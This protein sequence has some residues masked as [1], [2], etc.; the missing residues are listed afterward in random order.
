V[1]G[2]IR[3]A[4]VLLVLAADAATVPAAPGRPLSYRPPVEPLQVVRPFDAPATPYG[5][6]HRGVDLAVRP[7]QLVHTAAP[8]TVTFAGSVAGRGVVVVAHA[9]GVRTEYEPVQAAVHTGT[10]VAADAV[11]GRVEGTH[12]SCAPGRCLHWGARRGAE[13]FD[14]LLLLARLGR[15]R[16][17]P[18][19]GG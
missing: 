15:V 4:A 7:G 14:P 10:V 1:G 6:G 18:W 2:V 12:G 5:P 8:G 3:V 9:D 11:L 17:L 16:L 19:D 13:Y